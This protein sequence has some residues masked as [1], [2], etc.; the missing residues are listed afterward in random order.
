MHHF[1]IKR[2]EQKC[3]WITSTI[4]QLIITRDRFKRNAI[5]TNL[6]IDWLNYKTI[7]NKVNIQLRN[8]KKNYYSTKIS[9]QKCNPK[10]AWKTIN[11]ILGRLSKPTVVNEL[12]LGEN[13]LT[14]TKD[15]AEGLK[16][17]KLILQI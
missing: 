17:A 3:S 6:D 10:E 12:K 4:K 5:I 15:I 1:N 11:N 9:D 8:A 2:L 13:S 14:N 7:R 16:L